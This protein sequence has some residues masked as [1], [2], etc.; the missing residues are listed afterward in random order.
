MPLSL[1]DLLFYRLHITR[2][3]VAALPKLTPTELHLRYLGTSIRYACG[4]TVSH[5][6][7]GR[8]L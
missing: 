4:L 7:T 6:C 1:M 8:E 5:G 3:L 2:L